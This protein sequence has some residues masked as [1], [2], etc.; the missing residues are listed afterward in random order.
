MPGKGSFDVGVQGAEQANAL[1]NPRGN[2]R[3]IARDYSM[4]KSKPGCLKCR[5][6]PDINVLLSIT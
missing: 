4:G 3:G 6:S 5:P 2:L 1:A